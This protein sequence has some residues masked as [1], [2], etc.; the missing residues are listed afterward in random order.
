MIEGR[1][2]HKA[3]AVALGDCHG[4]SLRNCDPIAEDSADAE[5]RRSPE[6]A[7]HTTPLSSNTEAEGKVVP[8]EALRTRVSAFLDAWTWEQAMRATG[9]SRR[10]LLRIERGGYCE[11]SELVAVRRVIGAS[12][13]VDRFRLPSADGGEPWKVP[14]SR[15]AADRDCRAVGGTLLEREQERHSGRL[16]AQARAS[17]PRSGGDSWTF[18]W[19]GER[20]PFGTLG[21]DSGERWHAIDIIAPLIWTREDRNRSPIFSSPSRARATCF[22]RDGMEP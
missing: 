9:L 16:P 7:A 15:D 20:R 4:S 12:R 19:R 6:G 21:R 10:T 5:I 3:S 18:E 11:E 8:S 2:G 1:V 14:R 13:A 17:G 22:S